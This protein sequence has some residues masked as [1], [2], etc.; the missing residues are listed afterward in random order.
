MV[1]RT[2]LKAVVD[3]DE[4]GNTVPCMDIDGKFIT[5]KRPIVSG[6]G[7]STEWVVVSYAPKKRNPYGACDDGVAC[8][9]RSCPKSHPRERYGIYS[10]RDGDNCEDPHCG[11]RHKS[12]SRRYGIRGCRVIYDTASEASY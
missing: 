4:H 12:G 9:L 3:T 7:S 6:G 8:K 5:K 1:K 10:C 2:L 11:Y